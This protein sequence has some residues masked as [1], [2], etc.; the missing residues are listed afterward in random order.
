MQRQEL[1][2]GGSR[3]EPRLKTHPAGSTLR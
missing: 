2:P 1:S 3:A